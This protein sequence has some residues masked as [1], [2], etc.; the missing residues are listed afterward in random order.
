MDI[1]EFETTIG[2]EIE[3]LELTV[4]PEKIENYE[5][6]TCRSKKDNWQTP[7]HVYE[8]IEEVHGGID[9][10]PCPGVEPE[11]T[12]IAENNIRPPRNGL[13]EPWPG[14][15]F[16]NEPFSDIAAWLEKAV[17]EVEEGAADVV[18]A[19]TPDG[20]DVASWWHEYISEHATV[21]F[22]FTSRV[23]FYN[24]DK[25]E[26]ESGVPF[27]TAISVFGDSPRELEKRWH[28]KG[29]VVYRPHNNGWPG[30]E[31]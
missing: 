11:E 2:G 8:D 20:T 24:P 29:D 4:Q 16:M 14:V 27:N 28:E 1:E 19:L 25:G 12:H 21:T 13:E 17:Y 30:L 5:W 31:E 10:D 15:V 6:F 26:I 7:E 3:E 9:T 18:Y 23:D 22:F